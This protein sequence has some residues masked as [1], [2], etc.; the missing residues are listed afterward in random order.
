M[1]KYIYGGGGGG[2]GQSLLSLSPNLSRKR[3]PRHMTPSILDNNMIQSN[4]GRRIGNKV[5]PIGG[6]QLG[7]SI[8]LLP[9]LIPLLALDFDGQ[10]P[11]AG[12]RGVDAKRRRS[13]DD[14]LSHAGTGDDH[15][16]RIG[17]AVRPH[18]T[19]FD[20]RLGASDLNAKRRAGNVHAGVENLEHVLAT[21]D[22][23]EHIMISRRFGS[24]RQDGASLDDLT[25]TDE[26]DG[27]FAAYGGGVVDAE[28]ARSADETGAKA[29]TV[30]THFCRLFAR[31]NDA[32]DFDVSNLVLLIYGRRRAR[33]EGRR[34][35]AAWCRGRGSVRR[36]H[37]VVFVSRGR[38]SRFGRGKSVWE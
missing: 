14:A 25:R 7:R 24:A 32:F 34:I 15:L 23:G 2:G 31:V 19:L 26:T 22:R 28:V 5:G 3:A 29:R 10:R 33:G 9:R 37:I 17:L 4:V 16:R 38:R 21:G 11:V 30:G 8:Q 13:P 20:V 36:C 18:G 1:H 35:D 12:V 6:I 27:E